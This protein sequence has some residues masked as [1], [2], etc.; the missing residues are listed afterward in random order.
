MEELNSASL[1]RAITR[2]LQN[3]DY[4]VV[5]MCVSLRRARNFVKTLTDLPAI[6]RVFFGDIGVPRI[7]FKNGSRIELV[8]LT[9]DARGRRCN[10]VLYESEV[11]ITDDCVR[12]LLQRMLVPYRYGVYE[13]MDGRL[14]TDA[15]RMIEGVRRYE[16]HEEAVQRSEELDEFLE[17]FSITE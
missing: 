1:L 2:C 11:D 12:D 16:R 9:D 8:P 6:D 3:V 14:L 4:N 15:S 13:S 17:S 5:I 7:N 10:E